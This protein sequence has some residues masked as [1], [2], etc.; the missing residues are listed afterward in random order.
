MVFWG[1]DVN[2]TEAVIPFD[3]TID[4]TK[5]VCFLDYVQMA[6]N[7]STSAALYEGSA[8]TR[9]IPDFCSGC[10]GAGSYSET[11]DFRD[12]PIVL[13]NDSTEAWLCISGG[14]Q[15]MVHGLVKYHFGYD[16]TN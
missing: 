9:V 14:A 15:G 1:S 5:Y 16:Q 7:S 3:P 11:W 10:E 8:G 13:Q 2:G 4:S 6:C 12:D